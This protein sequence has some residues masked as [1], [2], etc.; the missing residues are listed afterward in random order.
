M[1]IHGKRLHGVRSSVAALV[2]DLPSFNRLP[3]RVQQNENEQS[4]VSAGIF[5]YDKKQHG[6]E[7][8][9]QIAEI[10]SLNLDR[11]RDELSR[12]WAQDRGNSI[13]FALSAC[14]MMRRI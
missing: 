10:H 6:L 7:R 2:H 14:S 11:I 13:I 8:Y 3:E 9:Q 1:K 12:Y 4:A 5:K